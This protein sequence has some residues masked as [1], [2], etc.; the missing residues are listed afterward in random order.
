VTGKGH[1]AQGLSKKGLVK[2]LLRQK[3]PKKGWGEGFSCGGRKPIIPEPFSTLDPGTAVVVASSL[4]LLMFGRRIDQAVGYNLTKNYKIMGV[5]E[6][7][8]PGWCITTDGMGE[9]KSYGEIPA[10]R[11][12]LTTAPTGRFVEEFLPKKEFPPSVSPGQ[13][14][15]A[16]YLP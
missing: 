12:S 5:K 11:E 9:K 4:A 14:P 8:G 3:M 16:I 13:L 6:N 15:V 1:S 10:K 2:E 7:L